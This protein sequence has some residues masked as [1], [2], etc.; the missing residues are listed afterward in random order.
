MKKNQLMRALFEMLYPNQDEA[1]KHLLDYIE[2]NSVKENQQP[3]FSKFGGEVL[4]PETTCCSRKQHVERT[5]I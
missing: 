4:L 5:A 3:W 1:K 2:L